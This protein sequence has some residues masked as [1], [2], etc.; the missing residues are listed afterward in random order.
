MTPADLLLIEWRNPWW[1]LLALQPGCVALWLRL[2]HTRFAQYADAP[3]HPWALH[4]AD[5]DT[6]SRW[7]RHLLIVV[8]GLLATAAAGPRLSLGTTESGTAVTPYHGGHI[9]VVLDVSPSMVTRDAAP[10]R[11]QRAHLE[12]QDL[13]QRLRGERIGLIAFAAHAGLL[14]PLTDDYAA[15]AHYLALADG[16]LFNKPGTHIATALDLALQTLPP[17]GE[18]SRAVLLI[19]DA[20]VDALSGAAGSAALAAALR[21]KQSGVA[22]YAMGVGVGDDTSTSL[23][24]RSDFAALR[25]LAAAGGGSMELARDGDSDWRALYDRGVL[26]LPTASR[27]ADKAQRWRELY[28][29]FL[30]VALVLLFAAAPIARVRSVAALPLAVAFVLAMPSAP[31]EAAETDDAKAWHHY[32]DGNFAQ[33]Q[34]LFGE[35]D[36]YDA[37]M[38]EGAAAY[39]RKLFAAAIDQFIAALLEAKTAT[40]RADALFNLGNGYFQAGQFRAAADAYADVLALRSN[41]T[42]AQT[43][44]EIAAARLKRA[45][46]A[47]PNAVGVLGRR[48][49]QTGGV[50]GEEIGDRPVMLEPSADEESKPVTGAA[51]SERARLRDSLDESLV[52][53]YRIDD[54][55]RLYRA[56]LKKRELAQ[57]RPA[58]LLREIVKRDT[59][60]MPAPIAP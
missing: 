49:P 2:R 33:A 45:R 32:R 57:D 51:G 31:L 4:H 50:L 12:V 21:L 7:R 5:Q 48:G 36:G 47:D 25:M 37:R 6:S 59:P 13:L 3:L 9:M 15:F 28:P 23:P 60:S 56:A 16:A 10:Q 34:L 11:L 30:L 22:F 17:S 39:R 19:T 1:L 54:P 58:D 53:A 24:A 43:N 55:D 26:T 14:A 44:L 52:P 41:D 46:I 35:L 20:N 42:P 40:Q 27:P 38:G 8:W 18:T 29:G